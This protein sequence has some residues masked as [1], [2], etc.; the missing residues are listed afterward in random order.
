[1]II[2]IVIGA[3]AGAVI[4]Y[5][6]HKFIGCRTRGCAIAGNRYLSIVYWAVLGGLAANII[7][8]LQINR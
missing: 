7:G 6:F 5:F 4:G 8:R 2:P 1:M 3:T